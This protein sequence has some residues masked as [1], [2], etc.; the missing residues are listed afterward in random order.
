MWTKIIA[1][2]GLLALLVAPALAQVPIPT[3][4]PDLT[5]RLLTAGA[6]VDALPDTIQDEVPLPDSPN[7]QI[8]FSYVKWFFSY[9]TAAELLGQ[10]MAPLGLT[11]FQM[12]M[13]IIPLLTIYMSVTAI[14]TVIKFIRWV[15]SLIIKLIEL[16]P[17]A[18]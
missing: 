4:P 9:N 10:R 6:E 12:L 11:L 3:V 17:F 5:N 14:T 18:E 15:V 2:I 13:V 8:L 16:I 1:L 7:P